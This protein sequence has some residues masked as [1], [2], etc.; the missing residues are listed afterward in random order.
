[1]RCSAKVVDGL[2]GF[3]VVFCGPTALRAQ[4]GVYLRLDGGMAFGDFELYP[5][6]SGAGGG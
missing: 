1:M 4:R 6:A 5:A 3:L 2:L